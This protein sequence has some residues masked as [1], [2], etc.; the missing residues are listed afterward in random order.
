MSSVYWSFEPDPARTAALR[1]EVD[2]RLWSSLHYIF[3]E[4]DGLDPGNSFDAWIARVER[5][6]RADPLIHLLFHALVA[7]LE[8]GD[9]NSANRI[10]ARMLAQEPAAPGLAIR[11]AEA[12]DDSARPVALFDRFADLEKAEQL[13]LTIPDPEA[14]AAALP[15]IEA[16]LR[17]IKANDPSLDGELH[18]L[19][20]E[21]LLVGQK[22]GHGFTAAAVSCFQAWG[23]LMVNPS[24]MRDALDV[25]EMI[26]HEVTHLTL[27]GLA[28]DE[29]LL[30]NDPE[31]L[32]Y[33][34][35]REAP[36]TMDGVYHATIVAARIWRALQA[37]ANAPGASDELK[38][39]S[40]ERAT[41][42]A[43]L[44]HDGV[45]VIEGAAQLMPIG[46]QVLDDCKAHVAG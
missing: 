25:V 30:T 29:P 24:Q 8:E 13:D 19:L 34:P 42:A 3:G 26:A 10:A 14:I 41:K 36:R 2:R 7:A 12:D 35:I 27:F 5:A 4:V 40:L 9:Q 18:A 21:L 32:H 6:E 46:R 22:P 39:L 44:F 45:A 31:E 16:G 17:L 20:S 1:A 15:H 23:S 11:S 28:I 33:S 37:Q 38:E 43:E